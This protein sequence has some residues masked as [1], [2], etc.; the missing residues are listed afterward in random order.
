MT[1]ETF[2]QVAQQAVEQVAAM[3]ER[4]LD[5]SLPRQFCFSWI[6][7]KEIAAE[8]DIP[9][10]LT[11]VTFV[12]ESRIWPCFDLFL[13]RLLPNGRLLLLGC[14]AGF[15]PCPFGEHFSYNG[16]GHDAGR[17]GPFKLGCSHIVEQLSS[18]E[19]VA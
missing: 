15:P 18:G 16:L 8:G 12:D 2:K 4:Q 13:E 6:A 14:R 19:A 3:A 10:F 9:E 1:R 11:S 17:V 7:Q 5:R